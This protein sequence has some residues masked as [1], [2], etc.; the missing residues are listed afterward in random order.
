MPFRNSLYKIKVK[1]VQ[2]DIIAQRVP[3]SVDLTR[4]RRTQKGE[5]VSLTEREFLLDT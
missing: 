4:N 5:P 1:F 2:S 3:N